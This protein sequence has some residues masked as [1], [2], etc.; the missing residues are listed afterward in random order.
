[1]RCAL[2]FYIWY[3]NFLAMTKT[4][5][6]IALISI[7]VLGCKPT[8]KDKKTEEIRLPLEVTISKQKLLDKI[9][10]GWAGQVIGVTYGG[11]VEFRFNGTMINDYQPIVWYDGYIKKTMENNPGLYDDLYMDLTFVDVFEKVGFDA[12]TRAHADAYA[13]ARY[14]L[15]HA[16]QVGRYNILNGIKAPLSGHWLN[17]PHADDIDFQIEADFSGLMSPGMPN[18]AAHIGDSIGHIMNYGDGWYGGVY[19]GALYSLAFVSD[20][21]H[22]I[23]REALKTIPEQSTYYQ[24]IAD[25]IK[26]HNA[27]PHDWKQTWFEIQKKWSD[28]TGCPDGVFSAFNIDAKINSAYIVLGLL[29]GN[30]DY[31]KTLEIAARAGQDADCNP[32]SAAGVLGTMLGYEKIPA[33]WKQGLK[34]AEDLDF[35]YT[36]MSLNDVYQIGFNHAL[37]VVEQNEGKVTPDSVTLKIQTPIAVRLEQSFEGHSPTERRSINQVL[38]KELS[39]EFDGIGFVLKAEAMPIGKSNWDYAGK[40]ILLVELKLDGSKIETITLPVSY[41]AR[42]HDLCWKYRLPKGKHHIE[43]TAKEVPKGFELKVWELLVYDKK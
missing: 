42:R 9:K 37:K 11:P 30:G 43:L 36:T 39:M 8:L 26:W 32:S 41:H 7:L 14:P 25:V 2:F 13:N 5:F 21:I 17:N 1:L 29:Y 6:I 38:K 12:P 33:Y 19:V 34:E 3:R 31:T 22:F 28:E 27:F 16:N 15:W 4:T 24:C 20:D 18:T 23:V 35:K 40:E 10:G